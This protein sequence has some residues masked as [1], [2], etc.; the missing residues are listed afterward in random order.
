VLGS[1]A[2]ENLPAESA[3]LRDIHQM[4]QAIDTEADAAVGAAKDAVE[5][6]IKY[7]LHTIGPVKLSGKEKLT[8]LADTLHREL[9]LHPKNVAPGVKGEES[10]KRVLGSMI[11][12][13]QALAELRNLFG[14]G[15]GRVARSALKPRHARLAANAADAYVIFILETL[16]D[17]GA[18]WRTTVRT[19]GS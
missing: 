18:P 9:A 3:V 13:V 12:Q 8:D 5:S 19:E 17:E 11:T 4:H 14:V 7:A 6:A 15:K 16:Q 1:A 10:V 2:P